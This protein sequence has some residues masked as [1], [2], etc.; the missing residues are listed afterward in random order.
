MRH[1]L[2][3]KP[4]H[5]FK[6]NTQ[7]SIFKHQGKEGLQR[8]FICKGGDSQ[9]KLV[10]LQ[11]KKGGSVNSWQQMVRHNP[12]WERKVTVSRGRKD[13]GLQTKA[14]TAGRLGVRGRPCTVFT[15]LVCRG[16]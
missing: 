10:L 12:R 4:D 7:G 6:W 9:I 11:E 2:F 13:E 5:G 3:Y 15:C 14:S 8:D 1:H 16:F